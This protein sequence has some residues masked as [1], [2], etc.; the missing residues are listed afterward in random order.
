MSS[1]KGS[2]LGVW[3]DAETRNRLTSAAE[4]IGIPRNKLIVNL[5]RVGLD[6][7]ELLQKTGVIKLYKAISSRGERI[8]ARI[9]SS[10][11][12]A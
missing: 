11:A 1:D 5:L 12:T 2:V 6:D 7:V 9:K 4:A 8:A 10:E 3:I